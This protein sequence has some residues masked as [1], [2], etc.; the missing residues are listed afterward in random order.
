MAAIY[1][2]VNKLADKV[3]PNI[4]TKTQYRWIN[5][6]IIDLNL[7]YIMPNIKKGKKYRAS[8]ILKKLNLIIYSD[9]MA[10]M[11]QIIKQNAIAPP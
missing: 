11:M 9:K 7:Q 6:S 5:E 3:K 8:F 10:D 1:P 4:T 2:E